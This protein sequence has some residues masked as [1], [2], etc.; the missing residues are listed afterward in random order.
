MKRR[1]AAVLLAGAPLAW[2]LVARAQPAKI[3]RIGFLTTAPLA[4]IRNRTE[5]FQQ[6]LRELGYVEVKTSSSSGD[7]R[8]VNK[9]ACRRLW[10]NWFASRS[11]S[12]SRA[13]KPADLPVE[14]PTKFE[15]VINLKTARALG[16]TIPQSVWLRADEVIQ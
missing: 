10:L 9:T 12:S 15:L 1:D 11:T 16:I 4:V 13:A 2:Q 7:R 14:Q 5:A 8:K 3:P 6:S